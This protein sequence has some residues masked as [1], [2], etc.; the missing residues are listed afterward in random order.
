MIAVLA[1][2]FIIVMII[3]CNRFIIREYTCASDKLHKDG[4]FI[5]LSDLHNK[6]FGKNNDK[7]YNAIVKQKPDGILIAGDMYTSEV[8]ER[9]L[10]TAEFVSRLSKK[11]AVYY[12]NGNHEHKTRIEPEIFGDMYEDYMGRVKSAGTTVL[13]NEDV[14][15][16]PYN[17]NIYGL[18]MERSFYKKFS[19]RQMETTYLE[20]LL[21]K[22]DPDSFNLLIAHNPEYFETYAK[23]GADL[24]VSG[25]VHGGLMRLP[26]LG[27]VISPKLR[28]FPRYDG[29]RFEKEGKIMILSR[30][31]GTHTLP[32]RIFNPGELIVIHLVRE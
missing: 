20:K 22:P 14:M 12:G 32:I 2:F 8:N 10:E 5:L 29:G 21:G 3:D 23:W 18:E 13:I 7:L 25:H 4:R 30:G 1:L 27:G 24:T 28:I 6:S 9:Y 15:L 31:L 19:N 26:V 11:Y 17:M 16:P